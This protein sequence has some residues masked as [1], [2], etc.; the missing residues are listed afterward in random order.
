MRV[1]T[2]TRPSNQPCPRRLTSL[3]AT[4]RF[5]HELVRQLRGG[6]VILLSGPIGS[7]KTTLVR[8]M[9]KRLGARSVVRSP[10]FTLLRQYDV[11]RGA[12]RQ[13]IHVDAYRLKNQRGLVALG[14]ESLGRPGVVSIIEW[15]P[16]GLVL[17]RGRI[18]RIRL[19][20]TGPRSRNAVVTRGAAGG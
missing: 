17:P 11:R 4:A 7:G 6:D 16:A 19:I 5:A 8:F 2:A 10:S 13:L 1:K 12:I 3:R 20:P 15:P 18:V 14:L 9:A